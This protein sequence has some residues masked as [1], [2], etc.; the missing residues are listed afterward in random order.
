MESESKCQDIDAVGQLTLSEARQAILRLAEKLTIPHKRFGDIYLTNGQNGTQAYLSVFHTKSPSSAGV[1]ASKLLKKGTDVRAY[2]DMC[3]RFTTDEA[4][5]HL[6]ITKTRIL[7]EESKLAFIDFRKMYDIDGEFLPPRLWPEEIA[8]AVAGFDVIQTWD[9]DNDK[10]KYKYKIKF[11]DKGRALQRLETVLGMN[12]ADG[13]QDED[14][15]LFKDF[16]SSIDGES[17]GTLPSEMSE[18]TE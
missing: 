11:N 10:W 2:V 9:P 14:R 13:L 3:M 4:L 7:D 1:G 15:D 18:D 6:T 5:S 8:R 17:R 16:L 12:K